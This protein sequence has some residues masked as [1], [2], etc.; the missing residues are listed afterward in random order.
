MHLVADVGTHAYLAIDKGPISDVHALIVAVEHYPNLATLKPEAWTDVEGLMRSLQ[1]A[2]KSRGLQLVG[3][4]RYAHMGV[5]SV[6]GMSKCATITQLAPGMQHHTNFWS[7]GSHCGAAYHSLPLFRYLA[8]HSRGGNHC[9]LN[10]IGISDA[11][12]AKAQQVFTSAA[13]KQGFSL[14]A[15][16]S[17]GDADKQAALKEVVGNGQYFL[18]F[19]AR[20]LSP[21][22]S[23][24]QVRSVHILSPTRSVCRSRSR[25]PA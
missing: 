22:A 3:F 4:E 17:M 8:F 24:P 25:L 20:R 7:T 5:P 16:P 19:S 15:L 6:S 12:A 21:C 11:Q 13:K 23:N 2:Y 10:F 18:A 9:H 14:D 1:A